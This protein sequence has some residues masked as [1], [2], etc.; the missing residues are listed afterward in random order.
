[1]WKLCIPSRGDQTRFFYSYL[2]DS[3][4]VLEASRCVASLKRIYFKTAVADCS[5]ITSPCP[6]TESKADHAS[7]RDDSTVVFMTV[8]QVEPASFGL[9]ANFKKRDGSQTSGLAYS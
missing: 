9:G 3:P 7:G 6:M 1:V 8:L 2:E 4:T 5:W